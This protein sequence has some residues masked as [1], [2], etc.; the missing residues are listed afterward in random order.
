MSRRH[1]VTH[2]VSAPAAA[3]RGTPG[4]SPSSF[5][6][7][8]DSA[9]CAPQ[10]VGDH[11]DSTRP[12]FPQK[13]ESTTGLP[14]RLKGRSKRF[15]ALSTGRS[16]P[17]SVREDAIEVDAAVVGA[18]RRIEGVVLEH[19]A[20][21]VGLSPPVTAGN[22]QIH[23]RAV[24]EDAVADGQVRPVRPQAFHVYAC[25]LAGGCHDCVVEK[26]LS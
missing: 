14:P 22:Q 16:C 10:Q 13:T 11:Q 15:C 26:T 4:R 23:D 1:R 9:G 7:S 3:R 24:L 20:A 8:P 17:R 2:S 25:V 5:R 18:L 12:V 19:D 6:A 21:V